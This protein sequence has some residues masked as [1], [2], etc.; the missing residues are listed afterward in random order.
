MPIIHPAH[1]AAAP[2]RE[3]VVAQVRLLVGGTGDDTVERNRQDTGLFGP[4]SA[5]WKVHG[6]FTS[7]MVGG[8]TALLLQMLHPGALAGVWDHSNFRQDMSGRLKRTARFI[9]GVTYGDRSEAQGLIDHVRSIHDRV[10]G[11][12]PDGSPYS[13]DDPDLLTWVHVAEV[14]AFLSA[15]IRY[16]APDFPPQEQDRYLREAAE[17]ARR[18]GATD[19]PQSRSE[20]AAYLRSVRPRLRYDQRTAAAPAMAL[21]FDAAKDLLPDWAAEMHGLRLSPARRFAARA[22][23]QAIGRGMRWALVNSAEARA[24]R[25]ADQLQSAGATA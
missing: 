20:I 15:Y 22:G 1:S 12:L 14:S 3:A 4:D 25:R 10:V 23:V 5:I 18:L 17:I 16:A 8:I 7:M 6:D 24:R 21:A 11:V 9:A 13:A 2:I 19:V